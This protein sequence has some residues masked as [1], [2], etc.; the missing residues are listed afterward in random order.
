MVVPYDFAGIEAR[1]R[2]RWQCDAL[3]QLD[4]E[5][6]DAANVFYNLVEFPYPSAEGL[7]VGHIFKYSGVDAFG[8][9][10][11]MRGRAVFQPIGFD[12]FG[13][14]TE[15]FALKVGEHPM[16]LTKRTTEAFRGQLSRGGMGWD[17]SRAINTSEPDYYRWTQW[18]LARLFE[19][20]LMYQAEAPVLWCPSCLTVLAR[21]QTENAGGTAVCERCGTGVVEREM[22]QWFLRMTAY[23]E[24]L[25]DGLDSLDWP[26]R[27]KRLQRQW[28]GR[29]EGVEID[30]GDLTVFTTRPDTLPCVT[31]LAVPAG[32]PA[33]GSTRPHPLTGM[34]VPVLAADY[35][36]ESYGT[37]AVMGVPAHDERDQRFASQQ[38]LPVSS[39]ELLAASEAAGVGRPVVRYR[40]RDWL[41]SRQRYWGP[42]IPIVHC[43]VCGPKAVPEE[44]LPVL[45]PYVEDFRPTGTGLSP[46]ASVPEFV[47]T[48]C[49][50]CG[51]PA[52]RETDVSD[53]FVDSSWYFL[54][55]PSNEFSD[56]PWDAGR[57]SSLLPV[58]FYAGGPEHVQRHHLYARFVTMA[59]HDL[60]L[61]GFEEPFPRIRLG[62][63]IIKAG[64]KM[65]KSRGNVVGPDDYSS[66][67][68]SDVLRCALLFTCPWE[69]GGDFHDNTIAGIERFFGRAWKT[70]TAP[71]VEGGGPEPLLERTILAVG[72]AIEKLSFNVGL[73]RLMEL[74]PTC[75]TDRS[76]KTFVKLLAPF[77]PH[78]AEELW[79]RLGQ[80]Y[81]VHTSPWPVADLAVLGS[82]PYQII[83]QVDGKVRAR[84]EVEP[85]A[86]EP[87]LVASALAA[88]GSGLRPKRVVVV[89]GRLVNLVT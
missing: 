19:A 58:D 36:I 17:W 6:V 73:A 9:Y 56:R 69:A 51:R 55:Y 13:I 83:V 80:P 11:Q 75:V 60:G 67:H 27:A 86:A 53:T 26:E 85:S 74:A 28:I 40:M 43:Q 45:L 89:P 15:N 4:L 14:H 8:R 52:R 39:A 57:T 79:E 54:R 50:G 49:P 12:A 1:W 59:L 31:F 41:I 33:A 76:K 88:V 5:S 23:A 78:L 81:S 34:P 38:G 30:F 37:G 47:D 77:A 3:Y 71:A 42:P 66:V 46:L 21:E 62:G 65:S 16:P 68:G 35:V 22:R 84:I 87:D 82:A 24:R 63:L 64:A 20:G 7:H 61:V 44:D 10:Q 32:H 18:I 25:L 2:E 70:I 48:T 72:E 29:S